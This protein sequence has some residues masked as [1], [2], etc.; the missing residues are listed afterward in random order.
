M[1]FL[2]AVS[3]SYDT[4]FFNELSLSHASIQ[5]RKSGQRQLLT[6]AQRGDG[7][8]AVQ[9]RGAK[10]GKA[11]GSRAAAWNALCS[12][13]QESPMPASLG[14]HTHHSGGTVP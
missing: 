2:E 14:M 7:G 11:G 3:V 10:L 8:E 13:N 9:H 6:E 12:T 5:S 4:I 1:P